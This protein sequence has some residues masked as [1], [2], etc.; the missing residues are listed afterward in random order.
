MWRVC[1]LMSVPQRK[2]RGW[3]GVALAA[4]PLCWWIQPPPAL[5]LVSVLLLFT[6]A[7]LCMALPIG[8]LGTRMVRFGSAVVLFATLLYGAVIGAIVSLV[9]GAVAQRVRRGQRELSLYAPVVALSALV[10]GLFYHE[11]GPAESVGAPEVWEWLRLLAAAVLFAAIRMVLL[12]WAEGGRHAHWRQIVRAEAIV[13]GVTL[14]AV[15]A[16]LM[17]H[18]EWNWMSVLLACAVGAVGLLAARALIHAHLAQRQIR[19]LRTMHRRL[20]AHVHPDHL[21]HDLGADFR[22]FLHFDRLSLWSY[23]RQEAHLQ[24]V[25]VYPPQQRSA[26]PPYLPV[27]GVLGKVLDHKKPLVLADA[28]RER[29]PEIARCFTGHLLMMPLAVHGYAWGVLALER[30]AP[31]EPF[32]RGDYEDIQVLVDHLTILL[33]NMRLYR[34]A[35]E[36]AVRDS[37]TGLLNH[38]RLHERLKEELSRALRYHHPMTVLMI[39]V[40]Y[41]KRYN[42]TFGHQQGDELLRILAET[43]RQNVRQ[44]DIVGRYGGEE[45]AIILPETDKHSAGVLA[46]RLCEVVANTPFPGHPGGSPVRCTISIGVASYPEDGFAISDLVAAADAALYRA[47]RFGKNRVV[48][49]P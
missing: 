44:S 37:L 19:A 12:W 6:L 38:R 1:V 43:L 45:F 40:D 31:R 10:S 36:M 17:V 39:D 2:R 25:G 16:V 11:G 29:L 7:L 22:R 4:V 21:L 28:V 18:R 32:V 9:A 15:L 3:W 33:E 13:E 41:F 24:M 26:L 20:L 23:A 49:A 8:R 42:D 5:H 46:R 47:K 48:V 14:P 34:Q 30:D 27:E 35:A